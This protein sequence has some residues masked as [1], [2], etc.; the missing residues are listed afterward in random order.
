MKRK[1]VDSVLGRLTPVTTA[2]LPDVAAKCPQVVT[3][4]LNHHALLVATSVRLQKAVAEALPAHCNSKQLR[5]A[6]T[7]SGDATDQAMW[8]KVK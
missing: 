4:V 6:L 8:F 1:S 7:A 5:D 2:T 3:H